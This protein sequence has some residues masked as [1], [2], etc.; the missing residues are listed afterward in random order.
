MD[1]NKDFEKYREYL[2]DIENFKNALWA[3]RS[4]SEYHGEYKLRLINFCEIVL[5]HM[6][7]SLMVDMTIVN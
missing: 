3:N 4:N 1:V 6:V 2:K 5:K 7:Y